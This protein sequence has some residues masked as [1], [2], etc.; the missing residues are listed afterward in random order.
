[1]MK[2]N[3]YVLSLLMVAAFVPAAVVAQQSWSDTEVRR[4]E[5]LWLGTL[6][7]LPPSPSNRVAND[8]DAARFGQRL[9]FDPR[10]SGNQEISCST[11]HAPDEGFAERK[12]VSEGMGRTAMNAPTVFGAAFSPWQFADGRADSL[13]GQALGP[14]EN[15]KEMG[16]DRLSVAR[17]IARYYRDEYTSVFGPIPAVLTRSGLPMRATP[18]GREVERANWERI[19][20]DDR[21]AISTVFAN[22]GKAI[23]AY[24]RYLVPGRG[25]WSRFDLFVDR[26]R[27][28]ERASN[29]VLTP[30]EEA[31][32]RLF[33]GQGNCI[34]CHS[35]PLMTDHDFH[36]TGQRL[37]Q[38][39]PLGRASG[40]QV[41]R[42]SEFTCLGQF[43]DAVRTSCVRLSTLLSVRLPPR[44][45]SAVKTASLRNVAHTAPYGV[46]GRFASLGEVLAHKNSPP[47]E[48]EL[49]PLGLTANQ[50]FQIEAF[51]LAVDAPVDSDPRW[52]EAPVR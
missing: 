25:R 6:P 47:A 44:D 36:D 28:P 20:P 40:V 7:D 14:L 16:N 13:W 37:A 48:S 33:V 43:S 4:I 42:D 41:L 1:M 46:D 8:P 26:L 45:N 23:E 50:L 11:C 2:P 39:Q 51:L 27:D 22:V 12:P 15:A 49:K 21:V 9:F 24:E 34:S 31:G 30:E 3:Q 18:L 10:L 5:S 52:L 38:N 32:L 29:N 17:T 35:S 19:N